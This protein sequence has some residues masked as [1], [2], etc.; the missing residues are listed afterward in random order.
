MSENDGMLAVLI[1]VPL[2]PANAGSNAPADAVA[3]WVAGT[4]YAA[5]TQIRRGNLV[6]ESVRDANAG[7]DPAI[8]ASTSGSAPWWLRIGYDNPWRAYDSNDSTATSAPGIL[9]L[10]MT[11]GSVDAIYLSELSGQRATVELRAVAGGPVVWS[12]QTV[13]SDSPRDN[14]YD[15]AFAPVDPVRDWIITGIPPY[16]NGELTITVDAGTGTASCGSVVAGHLEV[17]GVAQYPAEI[18]WTNYSQITTKFAA[19]SITPQ[20]S[21][22][23]MKATAAVEEAAAPHVRRV[24]EQ[25]QSRACVWI[26]GDSPQFDG[27]RIFGLADTDLTWPEPGL[28][29]LNAAVR[30]ITMEFPDQ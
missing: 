4:T 5:G 23:N 14:W 13:L 1:P 10:V 3:D 9:R 21:R 20:P 2:G 25:I 17:L 7:H 27:L 16:R 8:A 12:A 19:T 30:G 18:S 11:P 22:R 24:L 15:W 6:Y 26:L 28:W 29:L